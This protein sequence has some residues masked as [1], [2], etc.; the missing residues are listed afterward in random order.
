VRFA[1]PTFLGEQL[2]V[3]VFD[4]GPASYAFEADSAGA[5]VISNGRVELW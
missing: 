2:E 5:R 1:T 3:H 4:A